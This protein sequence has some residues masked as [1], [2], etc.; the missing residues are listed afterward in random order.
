[1]RASALARENRFNLNFRAQRFCHEPYTFNSDTSLAGIAF[2][3]ERRTKSLQPSIFAT[4]DHFRLP[5]LR[6]APL[7]ARMP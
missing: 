2:S 5:R 6:D 1:M 7:L 3:G 4:R